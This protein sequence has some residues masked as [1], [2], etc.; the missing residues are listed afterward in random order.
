MEPGKASGGQESGAAS[1]RI[2]SQLLKGVLE[3]CVLALMRDE[4]KYG[5]ELLRELQ[6]TGALATGQGTVYPLLSRLRREELV[7]TTWRESTTG[8]PRRYYELSEAGHAALAR[9]AAV[10][11]GF[12][13][14]VDHLVIPGKGLGA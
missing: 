2:E 1:G 12:R 9:F 5:V 14:A 8:P 3:Y 13:T 7:V 11:P 4:P 6:E 10:W